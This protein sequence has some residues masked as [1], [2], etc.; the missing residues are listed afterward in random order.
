MLH[1]KV[2][3]ISDLLYRAYKKSSSTKI[4]L[5][6]SAEAALTDIS[7]KAKALVLVFKPE[8]ERVLFY[9]TAVDVFKVFHYLSDNACLTGSAMLL[10]FA[11]SREI[12]EFGEEWP[13]VSCY[14]DQFLICQTGLTA[15]FNLLVQV[16][17]WRL[18]L[19]W[20]CVENVR[21]VNVP[22]LTTTDSS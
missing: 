12:L 1:Y 10:N 5:S 19:R 22:L 13:N 2:F 4:T 9:Q 6:A 16:S 17:A 8:H 11:R 3:L 21:N 14:G 15:H 20:W 7:F 18:Q